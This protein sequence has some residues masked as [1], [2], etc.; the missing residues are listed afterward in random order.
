M[1]Q[2]RRAV[3]PG[4]FDP[5]TRGHLDVITRAAELFDEVV[6]AVGANP[7]KNTGLFTVPERVDLLRAACAGLARVR[8]DTFSGLV[9]DYCTSIDAGTVVKGLRSPADY[10]YELPMAD[11]NRRMTGLETVFL[12][13]ASQWTSVSSSLVRDIAR[14]GGDV[15]EFV[16]EAVVT[17]LAE[18]GGI[19]RD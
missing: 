6:V 14:F 13:S 4:S 2:L 12:A 15:S 1:A 18:Q 7:G 9:V 5:V 8:V 19:G 10:G 17:A 3:C 11:L 16:P